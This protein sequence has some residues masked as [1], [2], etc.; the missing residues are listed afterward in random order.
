M[1]NK[2]EDHFHLSNKKA[3]FLNMKNYY[4]AVKE[5]I[6]FA[7]PLTF[8]IKSLTDPEHYKFKDY[9]LRTQSEATN[10]NTN[11]WIIKPGENT[12]RGQGIEVRK[13]LSEIEQLIREYEGD[14]R[15]VIVQKYI[16]NPLLI[17]KRKF[18]IR[19]YALVTSVNGIIKAYFYRDGYL[20]T[21]CKEF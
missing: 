10:S 16:H 9:Y 19:C 18:D 11:I 13:E 12:N 4:E 15:T 17:N 6:S 20:R 8:H 1:Y 14:K 2:L 21:S 3:L 5:D 7:L